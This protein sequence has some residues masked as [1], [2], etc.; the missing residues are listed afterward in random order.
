MVLQ[1]RLED[2]FVKLDQLAQL[3]PSKESVEER[4]QLETKNSQLE[5]ELNLQRSQFEDL[6]A[7]L[8]ET[9][10]QI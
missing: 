9:S 8:L 6:A 2:S 1:G 3:V 7:K 10:K 4:K 5:Q